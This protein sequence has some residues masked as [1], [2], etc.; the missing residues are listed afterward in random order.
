MKTSALLRIGFLAIAVLAGAGAARAAED[1]G[2]VRS[3]MEKRIGSVNAL[4]DRGAVGENNRGLLEGRG[5][6]GGAGWGDGRRVPDREGGGLAAR[7]PAGR[8]GARAAPP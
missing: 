1:L 4:K 3:R 2:A 5:A 6:L 8:S 7:A